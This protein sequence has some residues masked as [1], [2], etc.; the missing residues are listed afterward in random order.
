MLDLAAYLTRI[1]Y[2]GPVNSTAEV[3]RRIHRS[4]MLTVPFEN[5]DIFLE[6][7]IVCDEQ[8]FIRKIIEENRGGFCYE[9]NGA[10]A[11]LL[12]ELGYTVTMLS[13]RVPRQDGALAPEFD[14][15]A[16]RVDLEDPWLAD[17]GFGDLF[18]EPIKLLPGVEQEQGSRRFRI[19]E[20]ND[21]YLLER[22]EPDGSWKRQ[23]VFSLQPRQLAEF[24]GMC[25]YHQTSPESHFTRKKLCSMATPDRRVTLSDQRLI[26]TSKD[27]KEEK[28]LGSEEEWHGALKSYF[29]IVLPDATSARSA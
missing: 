7:E 20:A 13:A 12:R 10:F 1:D 2:S 8:R 6:R 15:L 22:T 23:Y 19:S 9:L 17:V 28:F 27:R 29:G 14:H 3:L 21:S 16:L 25:R 5:L 11:A 24:A 26:L 18:L 4:H